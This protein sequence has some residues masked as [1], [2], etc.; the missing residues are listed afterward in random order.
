[1]N[2]TIRGLLAG[3]TGLLMGSLAHAGLISVASSEFAGPGAQNDC[4]G[5]FGQG[6]ESCEINGSSIIGKFEFDDGIADGSELNMTKFASVDGTEFSVSFNPG[7][8][9][10]GS[11]TY[12]PG[13]GDPS[14]RYWTAKG[15]N[16]GFSLFFVVDDSLDAACAADPLATSCLDGA[17][18]QTAGFFATPTVQ[19]LSHI[20]FYNGSVSV[21]EPGSLALLGFGL[22]ALGGLRRRRSTA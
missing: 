9:G 11:W 18:P 12:T 16:S 20:S 8:D 17:S 1:M 4:S 21:P 5:F 2:T 19:A 3:A 14:V 6:F 15:G 13:S 7:S 10:S 22:L